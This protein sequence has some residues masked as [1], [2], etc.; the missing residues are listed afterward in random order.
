MGGGRKLRPK[1][2][3]LG[4]KAE[5]VGTNRV[6]LEAA[7]EAKGQWRPEERWE[8]GANSSYGQGHKLSTKE[9][10]PRLRLSPL[11]RVSELNWSTCQLVTCRQG[12]T[13]GIL[14]I[15]PSLPSVNLL[16]SVP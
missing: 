9:A 13:H 3:G 10:G 2:F 4:L 1:I 11:S 8:A 12:H 15:H 5:R 7:D 6:R 14:L 16:A